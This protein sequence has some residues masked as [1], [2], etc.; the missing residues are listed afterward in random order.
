MADLGIRPMTSAEF[1]E[2]ESEAIEEYAHD[3]SA[4][5]GIPLENARRIAEET[6]RRL[7]PEGLSTP[8]T[9]IV[10]GEDTAGGRI[11]ILWVGPNPDGV[12][13]AWIYDIEVVAPRRG[14]GWGRAL[15][16]EA[17][18]LARE[19]GHSEI[20]LNVFGSNAVARGLYESLGYAATSIQMRKPL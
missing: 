20:G 14:E 11:G 5:R 4:A 18:R 15:M 10:I 9:H 12:G 2:W 7:L 17:D 8:G 19:D 1:V 16:A 13:P 3:I 6:H